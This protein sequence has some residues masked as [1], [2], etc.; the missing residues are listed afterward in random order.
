MDFCQ[1]LFGAE[2]VFMKVWVDAGYEIW[3]PCDHI[4]TLHLHQDRIHFQQYATIDT[5][6]NRVYNLKTSLPPL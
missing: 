2:N 1:N 4:I 5:P 3:N 6:E